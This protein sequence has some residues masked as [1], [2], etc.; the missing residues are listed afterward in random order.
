MN[1]LIIE[2]L[3]WKKMNDLIPAIIQNINTLQVLMLGYVNQ[4]S[5]AQTLAIEKVTFYS[6]SKQRL[7]TKGET[8]CNFLHVVKIIPD[9]DNDSIL[10]LVKPDGPT[11]HLGTSSCFKDSG[12]TNIYFLEK[13]E[14]IIAARYKDLPEGSYTTKLFTQG[15][16]RITQKVGEEAVEVVIAAL[17]EPKDTLSN[18]VAD[19]I[20]HLLVL[21]KAKDIR[22][23]DAAEILEKRHKLKNRQDL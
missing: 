17:E 11:C 15:L 16:N 13:L 21:L 6:R 4:E 12:K 14:A 7:W 20:Y 18:E 8:S 23:A 10:I 3:D 19:L 2:Q 5:L 9:C 1:K 22:L